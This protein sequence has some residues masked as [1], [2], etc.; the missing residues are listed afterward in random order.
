MVWFLITNSWSFSLED[1][2]IKDISLNSP[3]SCRRIREPLPRRIQPLSEEDAH[4]LTVRINELLTSRQLE[5]M[6]PIKIDG[7]SYSIEMDKPSEFLSRDTLRVIRIGPIIFITLTEDSPES[8]NARIEELK[9]ILNE[10]LGEVYLQNK[11][12]ILFVNPSSYYQ[13]EFTISPYTRAM[14]AGMLSKSGEL[15]DKTIID[16]GAGDGILSRVALGLGA[17]RVILVERD[18]Q[19]L[20]RAR[21]FFNA[22]GW[23]E[24]LEENGDFLILQA[25][26]TQPNFNNFV[27]SYKLDTTVNVALVNIG[28]WR[29]YGDANW[30]AVELVSK[31]EPVSL[32]ING[33][34]LSGELVHEDELKYIQQLLQE[35]D[36]QLSLFIHRGAKTLIATPVIR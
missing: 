32:I 28:P 30:K 18:V 26:L 36:Y 31:W 6:E 8:L 19:A 27:R 12:N 20:N 14:I 24:F 4:N 3:V 34:Y 2:Q 7:K 33:G 5:S 9:G 1:V 11:G 13:D 17:S 10:R 21:V 25:D 35:R 29:Q 15:I 22:Q 16:M 23:Q